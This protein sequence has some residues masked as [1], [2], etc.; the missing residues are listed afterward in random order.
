[1]STPLATEKKLGFE[2]SCEGLDNEELF[3][4]TK[5]VKRIL[6]NLVTTNAR[7]HAHAHTHARAQSHILLSF[8]SF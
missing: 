2:V 7:M 8:S 1:M 3:G 6:Q 5:D 4:P